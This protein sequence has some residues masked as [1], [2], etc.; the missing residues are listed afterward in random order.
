MPWEETEP[1][2]ERIKFMLEV[3]SGVF[4][5]SEICQRYG[6]SRKTGYKWWKRFSEGGVEALRDQ[7]RAPHHCPHRTPQEV[8]DK[9]VEMCKKHPSGAVSLRYRLE[10]RYP[11]IE[12]PAVSTIGEILKRRGESKP[13]KRRARKPQGIFSTSQVETEERRGL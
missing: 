10:R 12:W 9:I 11:Q 7:S 13:R 8:E 3:E 1:M 2:M 5:F 4:R 6:V